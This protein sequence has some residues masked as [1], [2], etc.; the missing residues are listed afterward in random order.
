MEL[1]KEYIAE[2]EDTIRRNYDVHISWG[3]NPHIRERYMTLKEFCKGAKK[4]LSVGCAGVEPWAIGATH[5]CDVSRVAYEF[6]KKNNWPGYFFVSSCD[7]IG[8]DDKEFDAAVCSEV[9]EHL[10]DLETIKK[11]FSELD[12]VSKKWIV[13]TPCVDVKE[14]THKF[15]FTEEQ[16]KNITEKFNTKII[17]KDIH[18]YIIKNGR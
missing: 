12:R 4:I 11:T 8:A 2:Q 17:K 7:N 15:L 16:L 18:F 10:P 13:T 1:T 5:A 14:P 9:I 6:L 3:N